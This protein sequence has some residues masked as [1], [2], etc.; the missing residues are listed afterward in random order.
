[1]GYNSSTIIK[2]ILKNNLA[3]FEKYFFGKGRVPLTAGG[4]A[5]WSRNASSEEGGL[6]ERRGLWPT[7]MTCRVKVSREEEG[8][9]TLRSHYGDGEV[10]KLLG[11]WYQVFQSNRHR[12]PGT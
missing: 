7:R 4:G 1:M 9:V 2:N 6:T 8:S 10:G 11:N 3:S 5:Q 12:F